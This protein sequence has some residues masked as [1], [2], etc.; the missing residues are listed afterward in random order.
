[1]AYVTGDTSDAKENR[2]DRADVTVNQVGPY[3]HGLDVLNHQFVFQAVSSD[4]VE[5]GS[6]TSVINA[7]AHSARVGD[8]IK[9]GFGATTALW[10]QYATVASVTT[11][12][13]T[14]AQTL[15]A[16]PT[17]SDTFEVLRFQPPRVDVDGDVQTHTKL[18]ID[19]GFGDQEINSSS[20]LPVSGTL[21]I[22]NNELLGY[23]GTPA[24]TISAVAQTHSALSPGTY[25]AGTV[26][27]FYFGV[28][29]ASTHTMVFEQSEDALNWYSCPAFEV[30]TTNPTLITS[31][32]GNSTAR[33]FVIPILAPGLSYR[34][35]CTVFSG[36]TFSLYSRIVPLAFVNQV[37]PLP[38]GTN[39][40]GKVIRADALVPLA[41]DFVDLGYTGS[42]LTSVVYKTG[43]AGGTTVATLTLAYAGGNLDTITRT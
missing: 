19:D 15:N 31:C 26:A 28:N 8:L 13:I 38:A 29:F 22:T 25:Q 4:T 7:T 18:Y 23:V 43:G 11:N 40:I 35:R 3:R 10:Y 36:A 9:F 39:T 6:T 5:T 30:P 37:F 24:T 2:V 1:M 12:T 33:V 41:H 34:M 17:T 20:P 27:A 42:D 16:T 14:L 21:S 32:T